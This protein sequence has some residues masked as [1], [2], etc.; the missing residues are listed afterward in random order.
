MIDRSQL[1]SHITLLCR[2]EISRHPTR[3]MERLGEA[4]A[5]CSASLFSST[6][7]HRSSFSLYKLPVTTSPFVHTKLDSTTAK[8]KLL[9][10]SIHYCF[11]AVGE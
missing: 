11:R 4:N 8:Q 6:E 9:Q 3:C 1:C 5:F 2:K 10:L 7:E